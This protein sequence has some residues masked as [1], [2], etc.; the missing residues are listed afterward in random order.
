MSIW[1]DLRE[2]VLA[3]LRGTRADRELDEEMRHHLELD[4]AARMR[5]GATADEARRQ[6][7]HAFGGV[8]RFREETRDARGVRPLEDLAFD[9]RFA[10]RTLRRNPGFTA[11]AVL[12]LGLGIGANTAIFSAVDAVVLRSLPF[13]D[14]DRLYMLYEHN[15]EKNW[16]RETAAPANMLDWRERVEAFE[17]IAAYESFETEAVLTGGGAAHFV[18]TMGVTGDFFDVLGVRA[19]SGR[20]FEEDE[21]WAGGERVAILSDRLWRQSFGADDAIVGR[22]IQLDGRPVR[23]VGVMPPGFGF[24]SDAIDLW[25]PMQWPLENRAQTFFRRAH[26]LRPIA[27]LADGADPQ[28]AAAQLEAVASQLEREY[29]GTNRLMGA[30]MTPLQEFLVGDTRTPLLVT[31]GAVGLLLLIGCANVANLLLVKAAGRRRELAVRCALGAG[32]LRLV[33]QLITESLVLALLGG[34]AGLLLGL[35]GTRLLVRLQPEGLLH[36]ATFGVDL[37]VLAYVTGLTLLS[38][39]LF[40]ALPALWSGR[41]RA[42]DALKEGG[43][44]GMGGPSTRRASGAIVIAEVAIATLLVMGAGLIGRSFAELLRVDPGFDVR[45]VLAVTLRVTDD[46][47]GSVEALQNVFV[48]VESRARALP[49]VES[50]AMTNRL[51]L[52]ESGYTSDFSIAGR[53]PDAYGTE[54]TH[55]SITPGYFQTLRVPLIAGRAFTAA[56]RDGA[57]PVVIL[58]QEVAR[59]YFP[60]ENPVGQRIAFDRA[61]DSTSTWNTIIGVV[62][63]ERQDHLSVNPRMEVFKPFAQETTPGMTLLLRMSHDALALLPAVREIV[64]AVDPDLPIYDAR[65]YE[66]VVADSLARERFFMVLLALFAATALVLAIVGVYGVTAQLVRQRTTEIGVRIALGATSRDVLRLVVGRTAAVLATGAVIGVVAALGATQL[67][68]GMLYGVAPNDLVTFIAAPMILV[69]TG[70]MTAWLPARRAS[71]T[72]PVTA[73]R[74]D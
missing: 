30:G 12:V 9:V 51:P 53:D 48:Q 10:L 65:A 15:P 74:T 60:G 41:A 63:S 19:A 66:T 3:L 56:D 69:G 17:V 40:G 36:A 68:A 31:L 5:A 71:R 22:A 58:N 38:G 59:R 33:R 54:I 37:R 26:W 72:P 32:R 42:S 46:R 11:A 50:A 73:L 8:D 14:P 21:T 43:R 61:P 34:G 23:V 16:D 35:A 64:A 25:R 47:A 2:R 44:S 29:P 57:R 70:L 28:T 39:L 49:G 7:L 24:P 4:I 55:R 20:T 67:L 45:G 62:G 6:A 27:R 52:L 13:A 18:S 1:T